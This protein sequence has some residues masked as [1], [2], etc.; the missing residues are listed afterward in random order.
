MQDGEIHIHGDAGDA[1]GGN[2]DGAATGMRGG[3][4]QVYGNA[5]VRAGQCMRRGLIVIR[6]RAGNDCAARMIAG[7]LCALGGIGTGSALG[8]R[9]GTLILAQPA[10][11]PASFQYVGKDS[12]IFLRLLWR[13]LA[14]R[15]RSLHFFR[16]LPILATTYRG[17]LS[18]GGKGEVLTL[19]REL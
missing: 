13:L 12:L 4:I 19:R 5:G 1:L 16:K 14:S 9:R 2:P 3:F 8:M 17:D 10:R 15:N 6:G 18:V 7:T 11:L